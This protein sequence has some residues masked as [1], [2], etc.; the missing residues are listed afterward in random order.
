MAN[1][2]QRAAATGYPAESE[3]QVVAPFLKPNNA[4]PTLPE[5]AAE[6]GA[7]STGEVFP[8]CAATDTVAKPGDRAATP[9]DIL[10][11]LTYGLDLL[12][13]PALFVA[14]AGRPH[15]PNLHPR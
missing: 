3:E 4:N 7:S 14:L 5:V 1:S 10:I 15:L 6:Q 12:P 11:A 9:N 8:A 13:H 2:T